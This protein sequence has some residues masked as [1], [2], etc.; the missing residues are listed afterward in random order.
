M[1]RHAARDGSRQRQSRLVAVAGARLG[2]GATTIALNLA[3]ELAR[4]GRRT[5]L[6]DADLD[7][8]D[9]AAMCKLHDAQSEGLTGVAE[10]L[11]ARRSLHEV[12]QNGPFGLSIVPGVCR[13]EQPDVWTEAAQDRLVRALRDLEGE[14]DF[15]VLDAGRGM[16]PAGH[17]FCDAADETL[18]VTTIDDEA[19][20]DAYATIKTTHFNGCRHT[21]RVL[22]NRVTVPR[23]AESVGERLAHTCRRFLGITADVA[24]RFVEDR[25]IAQASQ[26]G[27]PLVV[28]SPR[29][30]VAR[31]IE[32]VAAMIQPAI[33]QPAPPL[34]HAPF[35]PSHSVLATA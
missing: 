3:T 15:V 35:A 34:P 6:V 11:T 20:K 23:D 26:A 8:G 25:R 4:L 24:G 12:L 13:V 9:I 16:S 22:F 1:M 19:I 21:T 17:R 10:V 14:V 32:R 18:I 30:P 28:Q 5:I 27:V 2:V 29:S 7:G 33:A 31:E